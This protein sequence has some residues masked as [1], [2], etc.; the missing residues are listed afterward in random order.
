[1]GESGS[2]KSTLGKLALGLLTPSA[3]EVLWEGKSRADLKSLPQEARL[4]IQG[5]TQNPYGVFNPRYR[6]GYALAEPLIYHG[7]LQNKQERLFRIRE[8][9][10]LINMEEDC[11]DKYPGQLSGGQVQRLALARVLLMDPR[12][13]VADE[14]TTM[15]DL[16]IQAQIL[17]LL[18]RIHEQT[19]AGILL[20]S[21]DLP[22]V[23][24]LARRIGM[25]YGGRLVEV[26]T[27]QDILNNALH[28]YT[29]LFLAA[30]R[31]EAFPELQNSSNNPTGCVY[32][33]N[34]YRVQELCAAKSPE[35]IP[36]GREHF[37]ACHFANEVKNG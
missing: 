32:R 29:Q 8:T 14:P 21:H 5:I 17:H 2:G 4:A 28:P 22:V 20:I 24:A 15:L 30:A 31:E 27:V 37:V 19:G 13:I 9:L 11:L 25:M 34:C 36:V 33:G 26:G 10:K 1:M 12:L 7:L 23:T 3:G 18:K 35:L 6:I 16:S